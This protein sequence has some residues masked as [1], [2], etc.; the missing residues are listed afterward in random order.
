VTGELVWD[1][2]VSG[3]FVWSVAWS[4]EGRRLAVGEGHGG[5][6]VWDAVTGEL[7]W[8]LGLPGGFVRPVAWSPD[9]RQ[10]AGGSDSGRVRVWDAVTG[11]PFRDL[12]S[13]GGPVWSVA[14]SPDGS[15]LACAHAGAVSLWNA[16]DGVQLGLLIPLA[17]GW[18]AVGGDG[19][20][21]KYE[22]TVNGEFWW[23]A[24]LCP[25]PPGE[26]D[27]Y[28]PQLR[29]V[30]AGAPLTDLASSFVARSLSES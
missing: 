30:A 19:F 4:P 11:E 23:A 14:W 12:D 9:G 3:G 24:N 13:S 10:L 8:D 29:R 6:R 16:A 20:T 27:P 15:R 2:G 26:L 17:D 28:Y 7:V 25:L 5:A 18:A 1:L 22:G 21:Y